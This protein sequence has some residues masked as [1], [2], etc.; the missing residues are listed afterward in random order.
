MAGARNITGLLALV[1]VSVDKETNPLPLEVVP[2]C[3]NRNIPSENSI[4]K[5][6]GNIKIRRELRFGSILFLFMNL[7]T[8]IRKPEE[9]KENIFNQ[10]HRS[11]KIQHQIA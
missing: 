9:K 1:I 5:K 3:R 6:K 10:V 8:R 4:S 2:A 7:Y 11:K